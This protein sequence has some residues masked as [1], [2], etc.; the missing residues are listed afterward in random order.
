[1]LDLLELQGPLLATVPLALA[2]ISS[3]ETHGTH[4]AQLTDSLVNS[5]DMPLLHTLLVS[6]TVRCIEVLASL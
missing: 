4:H 1:M 5:V 3:A 2:S 6:G